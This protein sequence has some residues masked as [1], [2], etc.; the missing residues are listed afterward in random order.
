AGGEHVAGSPY[1][2]TQ[3]TLVAN[4]DY[5]ISFTGASLTIT[6]ATL[7]VAANAQSKVYGASD[8][9]LTFVATG[10][11]FSDTE[12]AVLSGALARAAGEHV[13]SYAITQGTLVANSDYTISFTGA[14]LTITPATLSVAANAQ[15]KVYGQGDPA[16][17]FVATGFQFSDTE[18]AVLSGV[19]AR[20]A[21]EHVAGSSYAITQGSL[22]ANS[23]YTI[24]FTGASLTIT[25]ATLS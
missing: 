5:T 24:S 18:A 22:V 16:L 13:A 17:T 1:A 10:F 8:P 21:G 2:I 7:S 20:A 6:P 25:P 4:S 3:G 12:A 14:S 15:S 9:A 19:L 11:Q 23:D